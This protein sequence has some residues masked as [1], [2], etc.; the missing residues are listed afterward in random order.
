MSELPWSK[1]ELNLDY[2]LGCGQ[3][4]RWYEEGGEWRGV[5]DDRE[6]FLRQHDNR[7]EVIGDL[8]LEELHSYF[9]MD[10]D[11]GPIYESIKKDGR[12]RELVEEYRGLRLI[13][14]DP[15]EC[16]VSFMLATCANIPRIRRM[17]ESLC[18]TFGEL[19]PG[20]RY[21]FPS[22]QGVLD[23]KNR[24][25][26]CGLGFRAE[27]IITF[28]KKVDGGEVD[29][30]QLRE[31]RYED[32]VQALKMHEGIGDKVADCIALFSLDHLCSFPVDVRIKKALSAQYGVDGYEEARE[33]GREYFG[34]YA[35][36]AQ[37]F[38]YLSQGECIRRKPAINRC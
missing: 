24:I 5:I 37:E 18:T 1:K 13:R 30:G 34:R 9:R 21:S 6:I 2:T 17:I 19:L 3:V 16:S 27:R 20:G 29:F 23:G 7:I 22:P 15:W 25:H 35:G 28:T 10:D 32:C 31:M 11:L 8:E 33:F 4:F 26:R 12:M 38:I 14:Q 36:Y